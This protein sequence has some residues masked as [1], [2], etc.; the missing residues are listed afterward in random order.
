[1]QNGKQYWHPQNTKSFDEREPNAP[2]LV[3]LTS[4]IK[5]EPILV[6]VVELHYLTPPPSTIPVAAGQHFLK[7]KKTPLLKQLI[8]A[9]VWSELR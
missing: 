7:Q 2:S 3:S 8:A 4:T 6:R 1:M 5:K 9:T